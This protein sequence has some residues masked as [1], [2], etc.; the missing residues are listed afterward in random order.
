MNED[1][2]LYLYEQCRRF[3]AADC[4]DALAS[5]VEDIAHH[6]FMKALAE[7]PEIRP[8]PGK[9]LAEC[10]EALAC[11][12]V[13]DACRQFSIRKARMLR[14]A[15]PVSPTDAMPEGDEP[16]PVEML[17]PASH[18]A[19]DEIVNELDA[20]FLPDWVRELRR[21]RYSLRGRDRDIVNAILAEAKRTGQAPSLR[22]VR[23]SLGMCWREFAVRRARLRRR[24][25]RAWNLFVDCQR[26]K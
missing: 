14:E 19:M 16:F 4:P 26:T 2:K 6:A 17:L 12:R 18:D 15:A 5:Q 1:P 22:R 24:F 20:H 10:L 9:T 13:I 3:A 21:V 25:R 11:L 7:L 23:H 8:Q